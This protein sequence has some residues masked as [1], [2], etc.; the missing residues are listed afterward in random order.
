MPKEEKRLAE[1]ERTARDHE[2]RLTALEA[3]LDPQ[4]LSATALELLLHEL[5]EQF[6]KEDK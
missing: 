5:D 4:K 1:L 3:K 2:Q 6:G